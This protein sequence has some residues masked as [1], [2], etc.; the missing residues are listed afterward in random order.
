MNINISRQSIYLLSLSI[1]LLLFVFIFSFTLLIPEGKEYRNKRFN[2]QKD[3]RELSK[4]VNYRDEVLEKLIKLRSE[5]KNIIR[6]F[7]R[8]FD[9][10]KFQNIHKKYFISLKVASKKK[11][12]NKKRFTI[13]EVNTTS[14]INSPQSFYEFLDAVNKS[15]WII[16]VNFPIRFKREN[17]LIRSSFTMK[18]YGLGKDTNETNSSLVDASE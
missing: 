5:N 3:F 13:Y 12:K 7:Q 11:Q 18:V 16:G 2:I 1:F 8:N 6:A 4:H 17:D 14:K 10:L 9:T 15:D